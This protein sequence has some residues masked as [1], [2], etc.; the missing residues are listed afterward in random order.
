MLAANC[1]ALFFKGVTISPAEWHVVELVNK[2]LKTFVDATSR[3]EG[4][5]PTGCTV[6]AEYKRVISELKALN[7]NHKIIQA[8]TKQSAK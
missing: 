5:G 3:V 6:L 7:P 1:K 8:W 4:N 2:V